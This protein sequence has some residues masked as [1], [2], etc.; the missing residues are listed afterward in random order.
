MQLILSNVLS[1][2]WAWV[3]KQSGRTFYE[4]FF[5]KNETSIETIELKSIKYHR[6]AY[7]APF[8]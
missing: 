7:K 1:I 5:Y 4:F 8:W 3:K 6:E 2:G